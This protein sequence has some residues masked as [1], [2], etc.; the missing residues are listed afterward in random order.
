MIE[1]SVISRI[2][3]V[4]QLDC[5]SLYDNY[6]LR[7]WPKNSCNKIIMEPKLRRLFICVALCF[8][9]VACPFSSIDGKRT[10]RAELRSLAYCAVPYC[11]VSEQTRRPRK[12]L[13]RLVHL[14]SISLPDI[15]RVHCFRRHLS[16]W[17]PVEW[18]KPDVRLSSYVSNWRISC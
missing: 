16:I 11:A 9:L 3:L 18:R 17:W 10:D 1:K 2:I 4:K 6:S 13:T 5:D 8:F 14:C 7:A 12:L 15:E